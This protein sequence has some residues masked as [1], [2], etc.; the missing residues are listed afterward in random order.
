MIRKK[1]HLP[2]SGQGGVQV[3]IRD[4]ERQMGDM[5]KNISKKSIYDLTNTDTKSPFIEEITRFIVPHKFK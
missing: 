1:F 2:N 5:A 3:K 4:L